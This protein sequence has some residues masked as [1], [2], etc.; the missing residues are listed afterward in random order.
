[1]LMF[2]PYSQ[3]KNNKNIFFGLTPIHIQL[4][5]YWMVKILNH[6]QESAR[7]FF[8][9]C[10]FKNNCHVSIW[11]FFEIGQSS[12]MLYN[13]LIFFSFSLKK[14]FLLCGRPFGK[15]MM[16]F[17]FFLIFWSLQKLAKLLPSA[18][19][20]MLVPH[21]R[22]GPMDRWT[23]R[24]TDKHPVPL[25]SSSLVDWWKDRRYSKTQGAGGEGGEGF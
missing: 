15:N 20:F 13:I 19:V 5:Q 6:E 18:A 24:H 1:M 21:W 9:F 12:I 16:I 3:Q 11:I 7:R 22:D 8:Y 10:I 4:C 14:Y 25:L 23:D 17:F 2:F